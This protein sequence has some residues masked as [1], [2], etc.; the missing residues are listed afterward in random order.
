MLK[1]EAKFSDIAAAAPPGIS[2]TAPPK[3]RPWMNPPKSVSVT[4]IAQQYIAAIGD[5]ASANSILEALETKMPLSIIA[6][7]FM[8]GG[9]SKGMHTLDAGVLVMPV[10]VEMLKTVAELN[11]I[12]YVVFPDDVESATVPPR[13]LKKVIGTT[14]QTIA[15]QA[16]TPEMPEEEQT[17]LMARKMKVSE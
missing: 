17:G 5:G 11:D 7:T 10:I 14:M 8:M 1:P 13:L 6:E 9:V 12:D 3:G 2:W 16:Q 4:D 15:E